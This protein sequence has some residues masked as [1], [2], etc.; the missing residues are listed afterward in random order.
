MHSLKRDLRATPLYREAASLHQRLRRP[1]SGQIS[2][3]V[4]LQA[5]PVAREAVFA[6]TLVDRL[7]GVPPTRICRIDL[8]TGDCRVATF[9]PHT[10][11]L[12]KYSP[13]GRTI[14]FLSDRD[15]GGDFQ[16]HLLDVT[17]GAVRSTPR[18]EGWVEYH[19]WS[20]D[21]QRL[22]LGVAG[23]GADIS[24]G[25][26]A[27][28]SRRQS[29][30]A[31]GWMPVVESGDETYQWRGVWIY[32]LETNRVQRIA[33]PGCN[34]WEA[35]WC[36]RDALAILS[37]SRPGEGHWYRACVKTVELGSQR[38]ETLYQPEDQLGG[39]AASPNGAYLAVV[40][41]VCSD[42]GLVAG[43]LRLIDMGSHK[44]H[45]VNTNG[46]DVSA[47]EWRSNTRLVMSKNTNGP[48][49]AAIR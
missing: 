45:Q 20:A 42:R 32:D 24:G 19:H 47:L 14:A 15:Q 49:H 28:P 41:A 43:D 9:G 23:H 37:S 35:V 11:R 12:P 18:V 8:D 29:D 25:Q 5:S 44:T 39:L 1:G 7:E 16:L 26:G 46:V 33:I 21:S 27:V 31:P 6:G 13:D 36:G 17:T 22:L 2:D 40:E 30:P 10:D 34:V 3:A 4:E 38:T 48:I